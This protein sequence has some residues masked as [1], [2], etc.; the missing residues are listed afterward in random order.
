MTQFIYPLQTVLANRLVSA[1]MTH[2]FVSFC[3]PMQSG[4]TGT[5][6][7]LARMY[8]GQVYFITAV[9]DIDLRNQNIKAFRGTNVTIIDK[10]ETKDLIQ[11]STLLGLA[12]VV[13]KGSLVVIDEAHYG[14]GSSA[15]LSPLFTYL[16][17]TLGCKIVA[18]SATNFVFLESGMGAQSATVFPTTQELAEARYVS[19]VHLAPNVVDLDDNTS[20]RT[21]M[22]NVIDKVPS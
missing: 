4:K 12:K 9:S 14:I 19:T 3:S 6:I 11:K 1:L 15:M 20:A 21:N 18:V 8:P 10:Y 13:Q 7:E 22:R 5:I 16:V 17:D 2:S